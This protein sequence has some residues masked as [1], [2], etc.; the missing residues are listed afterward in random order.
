MLMPFPTFR[1]ERG[2]DHTVVMMISLKCLN[3]FQIYLTD[4]VDPSL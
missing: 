1:G 3:V 4:I 2:G